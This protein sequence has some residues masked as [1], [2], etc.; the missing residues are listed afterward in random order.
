MIAVVAAIPVSYALDLACR[1]F[2]PHLFIPFQFIIFLLAMAT[3]FWLF[4]VAQGEVWQEKP[5]GLPPYLFT[6]PIRTGTLVTVR[7]ACGILAVVSFHFAWTQSIFPT[8]QIQLP[9]YGLPIHL[10]TLSCMMV[11]AQAV[12]WSL[13]AFPLLRIFAL[14]IALTGCGILGI[15]VPSD[16]FRQLSPTALATILVGILILGWTSAILGVARDRRG[17]W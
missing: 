3:I 1:R 11:L 13:H 12:V 17:E 5:W 10:L 15:A 7:I 14:T 2:S 6:L 9:R 4:S 16:D 8:W